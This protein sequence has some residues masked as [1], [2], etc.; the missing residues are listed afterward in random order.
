MFLLSPLI[1][2]TYPH[3][4]CRYAERTLYTIASNGQHV[5]MHHVDEVSIYT[6]CPAGLTERIAG[7]LERDVQQQFWPEL[8]NPFACSH[9]GRLWAELVQDNERGCSLIEVR[10]VQ[11][12]GE[13][14]PPIMTSSARQVRDM[15]FTLDGRSLVAFC[16]AEEGQSTCY[17]HVYEVETGILTASISAVSKHRR[18]RR[19]VSISRDSK[20]AIVSN[21]YEIMVF[22]LSPAALTLHYTKLT[23]SIFPESVTGTPNDLRWARRLDEGELTVHRLRAGLADEVQVV[24][25]NSWALG[26]AFS[27]DMSLLGVYNDHRD[28]GLALYIVDEGMQPFR[29]LRPGT[30]LDP[31]HP[32][33]TIYIVFPDDHPE[34]VICSNGENTRLWHIPSGT[35]AMETDRENPLVMDYAKYEHFVG[36]TEVPEGWLSWLFGQ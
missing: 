13:E 20:F 27:P 15:A 1:I 26:A 23:R 32:L 19:Y 4:E 11:K 33:N 5:V 14:Y 3:L 36:R 29:Q 6:M 34:F 22:C 9:N 18:K 21:D 2:C 8:S 7:R 30:Y 35:L 16:Y 24:N 17:L 12:T 31:W 28:L 25:K 10:P